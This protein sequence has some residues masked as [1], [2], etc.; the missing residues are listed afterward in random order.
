[1]NRPPRLR[2]IPRLALTLDDESRT[3]VA[4]NLLLGVRHAVVM[5]LYS[6]AGRIG[7]GGTSCLLCRLRKSFSFNPLLTVAVNVDVR[8]VCTDELSVV[9]KVAPDFFLQTNLN[10]RS[11]GLFRWCFEKCQ[12]FVSS[13][14]AACTTGRI[15]RRMARLSRA[16]KTLP[17]AARG[18]LERPHESL[19]ARNRAKKWGRSSPTR[20][21]A[22][23]QIGRHAIHKLLPFGHLLNRQGDGESD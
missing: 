18:R 6:R 19:W 21:F 17:R 23:V 3:A 14:Q 2:G 7:L 22:R 20:C 8:R 12:R 10:G 1:M 11:L 16:G 4:T 15:T 13:L 9:V 5:T